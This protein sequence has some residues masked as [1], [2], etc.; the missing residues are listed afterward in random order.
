MGFTYAEEDE[1][2]RRLMLVRSGHQKE[3]PDG[4]YKCCL[5]LQSANTAHVT[6]ELLISCDSESYVDQSL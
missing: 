3:H 6:L 4:R 2:K 1:R 5:P